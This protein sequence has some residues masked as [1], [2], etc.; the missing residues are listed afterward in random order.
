[1]GENKT[2][3]NNIQA[4]LRNHKMRNEILP[5][6]PQDCQQNGTILIFIVV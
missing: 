5:F 1:M 3:Q 4:Y 2:K 6:W